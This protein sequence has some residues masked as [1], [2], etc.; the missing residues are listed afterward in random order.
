MKA[1]SSS[2]LQMAL[3]VI[4]VSCLILT[5][6]AA[7]SQCTINIKTSDSALVCGE[8]ARLTINSDWQIANTITLNRIRCLSFPKKL[9]G[10][11]A[12]D[13]GS[14]YKTTN[15]GASFTQC[16][17]PKLNTTIRAIWFLNADTGLT[18]TSDA[19]IFK[20]IN[21]G[22]SWTSMNYPYVVP[23]SVYT[24]NSKTFSSTFFTSNNVGFVG[25]A[26]YSPSGISQAILFK[27][28]DGGNTWTQLSIPNNKPIDKI[29]FLD[30]LTGFL[31]TN[32][33]LLKTTNGGASWTS[34]Y[35]HPSLYFNDV[36]F[37]NKD[38]GFVASNGILKTLD[39]GT[40]WNP[41]ATP[42]SFPGIIGSDQN[43]FI[44]VINGTEIYKSINLGNKW[45]KLGINGSLPSMGNYITD[46]SFSH[47]H[48]G[49]ATGFNAQNGLGFILKLD[50]IDS[51]K[52]IPG[53]GLTDSLNKSPIVYPN[54]STTYFVTAWLGN[55]TAQSDITILVEPVEISLKKSQIIACGDSLQLSPTSNFTPS[56]D[57]SYQW[58]PSNFLSDPS[59]R[60]PIAKVK[61]S[62]RYT[63]L[64]TNGKGCFDTAT[65]T[66]ALNFGVNAPENSYL[67]C[68][69]A[70]PLKI[71]EGGWT[72]QVLDISSI[73][74]NALTDVDFPHPDTAF[75]TNGTNIWRS[76]DKGKTW[77][78]VYSKAS[79][80]GIRPNKTFFRNTRLGFATGFNDG[81]MTGAILKTTN[82]TNWQAVTLPGNYNIP[83][84][85]F[86]SDQLGFAIGNSGKILKSTNSG[87]NWVA[88][89]TGVTH[90]LNDIYF[91]SVSTGYACGASG[92]I[93]KTIDGG[94]SWTS[95]N[96]GIIAQLQTIH[97]T[98]QDSGFVAGT[99]DT[100]WRTVN[101]GSTWIPFRYN[102]NSKA[103]YVFKDI[104]F[105]NNQTGYMI[106]QYS[107]VIP[108]FNGAAIFE[109]KNGG[110]TWERNT[111]ADSST[112]M[113]AIYAD[114][115]GFGMAVGEN[116]SA[117]LKNIGPNSFEWSPSE[118]L[119]QTTG[120]SVI[121]N[122]TQTKT[123]TV[124]ASINDCFEKDSVTI[125]V[126]PFMNPATRNVELVCGDSFSFTK[127]NVH[128]EIQA[129]M[130]GLSSWEILNA[131]GVKVMQSK[132]DERV[133]G[134]YV[135]PPGNYTF[136][137]RPIVMPPPL[138]IRIIPIVGDSISEYIA[139]TFDSVIVR[140]FT[141]ANT[142][143]YNYQWWPNQS[144]ITPATLEK[145]Y[146][147]N[148]TS[149]DGC[150]GSDSIKIIPK[151]LRIKL[152]KSRYGFQHH[153][154]SCGSGM[155]LDSII[156]NYTG[157]N[158]LK[159]IWSEPIAVR[160]TNSFYPYLHPNKSGVIY[161]SAYDTVG[162]LAIDSV[163]FTIEPLFARVID[164]SVTCKTSFRPT[165][166]TNY[167]GLKALQALWQPITDLDSANLLK[168]L[169]T[170][171]ANRDYFVQFSTFNG[172][173][174]QDSFQ[175]RLARGTAPSLCLVSVDAQN[176]N[177]IIWNK[178][179]SIN[180]EKFSLFK[181]TNITD[182]YNKIAE[183]LVSADFIYTDS[184]SFPMVQSNKYKLERTD[185]CGLNSLWSEPHKTMHLTIN[186]G[187]GTTWNLIWN[188]YEGFQV[189]TYNIYRGT[190]P[191]NL[192]QIGTSS[193]SN[194]SY[195][196]LS[197]PAGDVYYQVEIIS[198]FTCSPTKTYNTSK[199]NIISNKNLSNK[200]Q[201]P[202][203]PITLYP[204][205]STG[206]IYLNMNSY[207]EENTISVMNLKGELLMKQVSNEQNIEISLTEFPSGL[208]VVLINN[209]KGSTHRFVVKE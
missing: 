30:S 130:Q 158:K 104:H 134:N 31:C 188:K 101:G 105:I 205:P 1:T 87:N 142:Q 115:S 198:P 191:T 75:I 156:S 38:T 154:L 164:T 33:K 37:I 118:G 117:L 208:Y 93:L 58:L 201:M 94:T 196:D 39:G 176:K 206:M 79:P 157:P 107:I 148:I 100:I 80:S 173:L 99:S 47:N 175:L 129:S 170:P 14:V 150:F 53:N 95:L 200:D 20:T 151:P 163:A 82:G 9:I 109:T 85:H 122:P 56:N 66:I 67:K 70:V 106:A 207:A 120:T 186:K 2:V 4:L 166:M 131:Q 202:I 36:T 140:S 149:P 63:V 41:I 51:V 136:K 96:T 92:T 64:A 112:T 65:T 141:I 153:Y 71:I 185:V 26:A 69:T 68:G 123:Y 126:M 62:T 197:A 102:Y 22:L 42:F 10:F 91:T 125:Q 59:A 108:M 74:N 182:Q 78:V 132:P 76:L 57:F 86:P 203:V 11:I 159:L 25:G 12:G 19:E 18:F 24:W 110:L 190:T 192:V 181:E 184:N 3:K 15:G 23:D 172:C 139:M 178:S 61:T 13:S 138:T 161:V 27:T 189:I 7:K 17:S 83:A 179:Q 174:A 49:I 114:A 155:Q 84:I 90:S 16:N 145:T 135:L 48:P 171:N 55:C 152:D 103:N 77:T 72:K 111:N 29:Y 60:N 5:T 177:Q 195:S 21:G 144:I 89:N 34:S 162:C 35:A 199:S 119:N 43:G 204:N 167:T 73:Y 28:I 165:I 209:N 193:G 113:Y 121:A 168:P 146:A 124:T 194:N 147:L 88:I 137:C 183:L 116:N 50:E 6:Q 127:P 97:F 133:F 169:I 46:I 180:T 54:A 52:W 40:T 8:P 44:Y 98:S 45:I 160:D 81:P 143:N 128:M 187:L 32:G